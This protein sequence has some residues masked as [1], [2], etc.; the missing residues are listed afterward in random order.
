MKRNAKKILDQIDKCDFSHVIEIDYK[1]QKKPSNEKLAKHMLFLAEG[2][3][4]INRKFKTENKAI[5]PTDDKPQNLDETFLYQSFKGCSKEYDQLF[6]E[7]LI[8]YDWRK[9]KEATQEQQQKNALDALYLSY[10][11]RQSAYQRKI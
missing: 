9:D 8:K 3:N 1:D 4:I 5:L 7:K 6:A 10:M 11:H 2:P